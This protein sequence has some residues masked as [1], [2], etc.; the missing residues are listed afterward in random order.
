MCENQLE[1]HKH[2]NSQP[3]HPT[4]PTNKAAPGS[5]D[6]PAHIPKTVGFFGN[7]SLER[8]TS[9][10]SCKLW[11]NRE[12]Q[13]SAFQKR[14]TC[15]SDTSHQIVRKTHRRVILV[16]HH[17]IQRRTFS[18]KQSK[19]N[20][21]HMADS[22]LFFSCHW[23]WQKQNDD[24]KKLVDGKATLSP[25]PIFGGIPGICHCDNRLFH[26]VRMLIHF[27]WGVMCEI[28]AV[29]ELL[30]TPEDAPQ[31]Q[32]ACGP[33]PVIVIWSCWSLTCTDMSSN[34]VCQLSP[35]LV[36]FCHVET[37]SFGEKIRPWR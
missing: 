21:L 8:K 33:R 20:P 18:Q 35:L 30:T 22:G 36:T 15:Q 11:T 29:E 6:N 3:Y 17:G 37:A 32:P 5:K 10:S 9:I 7:N 12:V 34:F 25:F 19:P 24:R 1:R 23:R 2:K 28:L 31:V 26:C 16:R 14:H 4:P 13:K 27:L